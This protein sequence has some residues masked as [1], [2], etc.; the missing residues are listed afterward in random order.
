MTVLVPA[1]ICPPAILGRTRNAAACVRKAEAGGWISSCTYAIGGHDALVQSILLRAQRGPVALSGYWTGEPGSVDKNGRAAGLGFDGA[2]RRDGAGVRRIT[3]TQLSHYLGDPSTEP[4][5]TA[6][7]AAKAAQLAAEDQEAMLVAIALMAEN[8]A[9]FVR[10]Q[11][12]GEDGDWC[13]G[14][15]IQ[16]PPFGRASCTRPALPGLPYCE[17]PCK[18]I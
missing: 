9:S 13:R 15:V 16:P 6:A 4:A 1:R 17:G 12:Q 8:G 14:Y 7:A 11:P 5:P 10:V 2:W 18:R 3:Y